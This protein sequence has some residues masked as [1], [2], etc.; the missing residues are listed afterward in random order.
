M[1]SEQPQHIPPAAKGKKV[2][3]GS[4]VLVAFSNKCNTRLKH[5]GSSYRIPRSV[6]DGI[7][8]EETENTNYIDIFVPYVNSNGDRFELRYPAK[9]EVQENETRLESFLNEKVFADLD[10]YIRH[11]LPL[12]DALRR[13]TKF[14]TITSDIDE[15]NDVLLLDV[16]RYSGKVVHEQTFRYP[17][18][19]ALQSK[20][21]LKPL[22]S[23][24]LRK[25]SG[26]L[27]SAAKKL[28]AAYS[29]GINTSSSICR[30]A[31]TISSASSSGILRTSMSIAKKSIR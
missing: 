25:K 31:S 21:D 14:S 26:K 18:Q 4:G 3:L 28:V 2:D 6:D 9:K 23:F 11:L 8:I 5:G 20:F 1:A 12:Q 30:K 27:P 24:S 19:A 16:R 10:K 29:K 15:E 7:C 22:L 13:V 17:L